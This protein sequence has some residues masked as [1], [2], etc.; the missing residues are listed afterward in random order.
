LPALSKRTGLPRDIL[1]ASILQSGASMIDRHH[2]T[3]YRWIAAMTVL[4]ALAGCEHGDLSFD[5]SS[6]MFEL[7]IGDGSHESQ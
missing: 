7:P 5:H 1:S 4:I 3:A 6:G 2:R